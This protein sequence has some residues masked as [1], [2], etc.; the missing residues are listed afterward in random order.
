M[1]L[2]QPFQDYPVDILEVRVFLWLS[3]WQIKQ[4]SQFIALKLRSSFIRWHDTKFKQNI[5]HLKY[6]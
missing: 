3:F 1:P 5:Y 4:N 2:R 6:S